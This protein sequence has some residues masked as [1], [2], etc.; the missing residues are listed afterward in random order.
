MGRG[1]DVECRARLPSGDEGGNA[2]G[3]AH[4]HDVQRAARCVGQERGALDGLGLGDRGS[5]LGESAETV[6]P[7]GQH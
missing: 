3:G 2:I 5:R 6:A 1:L 4:M 7:A